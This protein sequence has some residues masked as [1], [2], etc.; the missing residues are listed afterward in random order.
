MGE[1]DIFAGKYG[2]RQY[3]RRIAIMLAH[4]LISTSRHTGL[5]LTQSAKDGTRY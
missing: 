2:H 3:I 4:S 1:E 5:A